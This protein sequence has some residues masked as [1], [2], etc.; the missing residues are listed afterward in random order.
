MIGM[1][2]K[3]IK[4]W[5]ILVKQCVDDEYERD[6]LTFDLKVCIIDFLDSIPELF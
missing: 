5:K 1:K 4:I 3:E 6:P 2:I